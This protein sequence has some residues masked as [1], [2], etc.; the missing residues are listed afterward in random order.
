VDEIHLMVHAGAAEGGL[1]LASMLLGAMARG[2]IAVI[3]ATTPEDLRRS[4]HAAGPLARRLQRIRVDEPGTAGTLEILIGV[5]PGYEE[6]HEV[7]IDESALRAAAA[8]GRWTYGLAGH[9]PDLALELLD[10]AC[11]EARLRRN[12][13]AG[14]TKPVVRAEDVDEVMA[15]RSG[16][17]ELTRG[18]RRAV[19]LARWAGGICRSTRGRWTHDE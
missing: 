3:G 2:E 18:R 1:D 16:A 4:L 9:Q 7:S 10:D 19:R 11:A 12:K 8:S 5:R 15:D 14:S 6:F 13:T 17:D